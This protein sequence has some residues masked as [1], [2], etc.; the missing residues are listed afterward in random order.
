MP[1]YD[2]RWDTALSQKSSAKVTP[3][4]SQRPADKPPDVQSPDI[5]PT[6]IPVSKNYL[7][8]GTLVS[9]GKPVLN[10]SSL[11]TLFKTRNPL[12]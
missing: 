12:T 7:P 5:C 1:W 9:P 4:Q 2:L 3:P 11:K 10:T 6:K 8:E